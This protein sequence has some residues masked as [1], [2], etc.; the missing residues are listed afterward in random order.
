MLFNLGSALAQIGAIV[1]VLFLLPYTCGA[2]RI[3]LGFDTRQLRR[4]YGIGVVAFFAIAPPVY[5]LQALLSYYFPEQHPYIEKLRSSPEFGSYFVIA[6]SVLLIAPFVEEFL[7][8]VLLQGWLERQFAAPFGVEPNGAAER[9]ETNTATDSIAVSASGLSAF[10]FQRAAPI[11][12]SAAIFASLHIGHG[13]APIPLF[14]FAIGLGYLYQCTHRIWPSL[15]VHFL[16]NAATFALLLS[17][18]AK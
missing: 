6:I 9:G 7:F 8:R 5:L 15:V 11:L 14:F 3:D 10:S 2:T 18:L 17:G 16:L 13:P 12:I 4:D 1:L